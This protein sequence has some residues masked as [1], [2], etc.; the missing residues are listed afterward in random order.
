[1][2]VARGLLL[3]SS[4]L[5]LGACAPSDHAL[6]SLAQR[7]DTQS[8][9]P[10]KAASIVTIHAPAEVVWRILTNVPA[11]PLWQPGI[12]K[13][14]GSDPLDAGASFTWQTGDTTIHSR[15]MLFDPPYRL[16]WIGRA[17]MAHA[18]HVFVLTPLGPHDTRIESRESMDG[19]LLDW[20]Y[21]SADLQSSE[22]LLLEN[23]KRAA[24]AMSASSEPS[25]THS[26]PATS[27][28][29][30]QA[31]VHQRNWPKRS[32]ASISSCTLPG[33]NAEWPASCTMRRSAS[34]QARCRSHALRIGQT[35]S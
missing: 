1:M 20:F 6:A 12:A 21:D 31:S 25:G 11:W 16:A 32:V 3:A 27:N 22:D 5:L 18:I 7:G 33:S 13:V 23:L 30:L 28:A 4:C 14:S 29:R 9:D 26:A 17:D 10:V 34:G 19:P 8:D 2:K 15:V 24:E 35:T